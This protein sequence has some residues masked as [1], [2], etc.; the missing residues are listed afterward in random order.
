MSLEPKTESVYFSVKG[1]VVIPRWL[2]KES[3]I[4]EDAE[5]VAGDLSRM[6]LEFVEADLELSRQAAIFKGTHKM[7]YAD[8]FAAALA[9]ARNCEL[10][11]GDLAFKAVEKEI[12]V[13][14]LK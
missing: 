7:S 13:N 12:K 2:R 9:K 8:C 10:L 3:E 14:W 4:E 6:P 5:A 11:T 1:Q